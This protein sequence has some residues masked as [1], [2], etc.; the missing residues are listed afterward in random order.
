MV[1]KPDLQKKD[2]DKDKKELL[3]ELKALRGHYSRLKAAVDRYERVAGKKELYRGL[4]D[5]EAER[6]RIKAQHDELREDEARRKVA[7]AVEFERKLLFDVLENLPAFIYLQARDHSIRFANQT[8]RK[9]FGEPENRPCYE[10]IQR[11]DAP[12]P[13]CPTFRVFDTLLPQQW[14][15]TDKMGNIYQIYDYPFTDVDGTPLVLEMGIDITE[16]K[17][18]EEAR[19]ESEANLAKAQRIT[20]LGNWEW[21]VKEDKV[22]CSD[23]FYRV[24][25]LDRRDYITFAEFIDTLYPGD[26]DRVNRAVEAAL[27]KGEPYSIDYCVIWPDGSE[28]IIHAEGEVTYG[29]GGAPIKMFG[30]VQD[31]TERKQAEEELLAS[32]EKFRALA[33]TSFV[34]I[35]VHRG[36]NLLYVNNATV[37]LTGHSK[38]ELLKMQ[39]WEVFAED[40]RE[41]IKKRASDR[42]AGK[43]ASTS[44]E[45]RILTK[46]G[47]TKWVNLTGGVFTFEGKPTI[48][49]TLFDI[50]GIKNAENELKESKTQAELYVDLMSHDIRN[51][52]QVGIGFLELALKSPDIDKKDKELLLKS[53]GA[54]E[55]STR[56]IDNV[57][58]LQKSQTGELKP[59]AVDACEAIM[60]VL[61]HY[62]NMPGVKATFN[63]KLPPGCTVMA[64]DLLYEVF[65]NL[66][67]NAIKHAGPEPTIN[68]KFEIIVFNGRNYNKFIVEDDGP[69]I[70]DD[71]KPRIFTRRIHSGARTRGSGLGLFIV[72][73][74]V[75]SYGGR[76]WVEDR[77]K[78]DHTK[79]A[80]FVVMLPAIKAE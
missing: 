23:E 60:R 50:T 75:D 29:Q 77:V 31:I 37:E 13:D 65:E 71:L 41:S 39:F 30:T 79:G 9:I 32:E 68:V 66:V 55:N 24:F 56:L 54:L 72:K 34:T 36:G 40:E 15:W 16:R 8:F 18:A 38:D 19:R 69:G 6:D 49:T 17:R 1:S 57:R 73:S 61:G 10:L 74:L 70:P 53:M 7:D 27:Y 44:Y 45:T 59:Y 48:I 28:H 21:D 64:N 33:D 25:G 76:V 67:G 3:E 46:D 2:E 35:A 5:L 14:E 12:C 80:R 78:G 26:K 62:S 52:N 63:Y 47:Q 43:S 42:L 58:K 11:S 51:M 4:Y 20:H 22:F